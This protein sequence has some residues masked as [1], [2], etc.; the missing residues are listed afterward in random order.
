[1]KDN[2]NNAL[3]KL[4]DQTAVA[5]EI[6]NAENTDWQVIQA[7]LS[8]KIAD[9]ILTPTQQGKL[10]RYV[11]INKHLGKYSQQEVLNQV[12]KL[13]NIS[14]RQAY[15]DLNHTKE[16][17]AGVL[18]IN[19]RFEQIQLIEACKK[20]IQKCEEMQDFK[21][22]AMHERNLVALL[23]DIP[24]E[25]PTPAAFEG[26]VFEVTFNPELLGAEKVD[27]KALLAAINDKRGKTIKLD[28]FEEL[29]HEDIPNE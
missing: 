6:L 29:D 23:K 15:T 27:M 1:M 28:M 21:S 8:S 18:N 3:Q 25:E 2:V 11:Y 22:A 16:L 26:H 14:L 13:F 19:K 17:F 9:H 5:A 12:V 20:R 24:E 10:D 7:Y 4:A